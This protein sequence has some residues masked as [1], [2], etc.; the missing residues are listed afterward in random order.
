MVFFALSP[1]NSCH[2]ELPAM[3]SEVPE[4]AVLWEANFL[5]VISGSSSDWRPSKTFYFYKGGFPI[6]SFE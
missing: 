6:E 3:K 4:N 2:L 1:L 5:E